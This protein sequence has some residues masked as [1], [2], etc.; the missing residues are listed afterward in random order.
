M[1]ELRGT[2]PQG[3]HTGFDTDGLQLRTIKFIRAPRKLFKVD[4]ARYCH[5]PRVNLE[6][7]SPG[8]LVGEG[9]LDLAVETAGTEEGRVEDVDTVR[10]SDDLITRL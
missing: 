5:L 1:A 3:N 8:G 2:L 10:C 9:E 6:N 7:A 4:I